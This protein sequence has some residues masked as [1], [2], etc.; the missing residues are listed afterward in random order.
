MKIMSAD[1]SVAASLGLGSKVCELVPSGT[2][3]VIT[4]AVPPAMFATMLVIGATVV[5]IFSGLP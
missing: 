2:T 5:A 4:E 3:P 1:S